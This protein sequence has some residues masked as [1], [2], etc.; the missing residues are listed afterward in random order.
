MPKLIIAKMDATA[1]DPPASYDIQ[2]FP[3]LYFVGKED[4]KAKPVQY[5]GAR[6]LDGFIQFLREHARC[7]LPLVA[8]L[9]SLAQVFFS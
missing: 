7:V 4:K 6:T 2:G 8:F 1:N 3:T 9:C 5:E